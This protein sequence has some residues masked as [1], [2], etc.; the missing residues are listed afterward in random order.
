MSA[1]K[2]CTPPKPSADGA[3]EL[4]PNGGNQS[5]TWTNLEERPCRASA[6]LRDTLLATVDST[7]QPPTNKYDIERVPGG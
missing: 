4:V 3:M 1:S 5:W 2:A 6:K 7:N